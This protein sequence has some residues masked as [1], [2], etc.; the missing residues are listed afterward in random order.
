VADTLQ[1]VI[2]GEAREA[3]VSALTS[4]LAALWRSAAEDTETHNAVIRACALTL[5]VY[6]ESEEAGREVSELL[7][8]LTLQ[9]PC[10]A[11][12]MV[13]RPEESPAGLS[14]WIS[15]V[16]QLPAPGEKQVCCEHIT[17][18]ARGDAVGDLDKVVVPLMVSGLPVYVWWREG[19]TTQPEPIEKMMRYVDRVILDSG[20]FAH[21]ETDLAAMSER[22]QR[23]GGRRGINDLN[24]ARITP[25][26]ELVAQCFDSEDTRPYLCRIND[27][28]IEYSGG[29]GKVDPS[30]GQ[31]LLFA[32]WLANRLGWQPAGLAP[33]GRAVEPRQDKEDGR[34]LSFTGRAGA[35]RVQLVPRRGAK[36]C[37][38][39]FLTVE[40]RAEG[41][42]PAS[43]SLTCGG[44][45]NVVI[46]RR[47]IPG[48][49]PIERTVR[50]QV[51][52]EIGL[53][54]EELKFPDRDQL[55]EQVLTM[56]GAMTAPHVEL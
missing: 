47:E 55:Y 53:L 31:G 6:T 27:V 17:I 45:K 1:S 52:D 49:Q 16:C 12:I 13:V 20:R 3:D 9:N 26:R 23:S 19:R 41:D 35:I 44:D 4:E 24:W 37:A 21:P 28:R 11:L 38:A 30:L 50:L 32:A 14:A 8:A 43:F 36:E 51:L 42:S 34:V 39:G 56:V 18:V 7:G 5:L 15:A 22:I 54:N 10:R 40:L 25:W 46:T 2:S 33:K 48:R 29:S